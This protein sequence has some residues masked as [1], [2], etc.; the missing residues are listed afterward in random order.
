M[1]QASRQITQFPRSRDALDALTLSQR[2]KVDEESPGPEIHVSR[3]R[4]ARGGAGAKSDAAWGGE[5]VALLLSDARAGKLCSTLALGYL[6]DFEQEHDTVRRGAV[7]RAILD[8]FFFAS[9]GAWSL[10][11]GYSALGM[12]RFSWHAVQAHEDADLLTA[13]QCTGAFILTDVPHLTAKALAL[14]EELSRFF[15]EP[16]HVKHTL[17][18]QQGIVGYEQAGDASASAEQFENRESFSFHGNW[19]DSRAAVA[20]YLQEPDR[21]LPTQ[22]RGVYTEYLRDVAH[23]ACALAAWIESCLRKS[24]TLAD[25]RGD[26]SVSF[27]KTFRYLG[28]SSSS[29]PTSVTGNGPHTDWNLLTLICGSRMADLQLLDRHTQTW[30]ACECAPD[31]AEFLV[32]VGDF[33]EAVSQGKTHSPVHRVNL[34]TQTRLSVVYFLYPEP[35]SIVPGWPY[36]EDHE[37]RKTGLYRD[38]SGRDVQPLNGYESWVAQGG[39]RAGDVFAAKWKQVQRTEEQAHA[40]YR[41]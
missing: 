38:Q 14:L 41:P 5:S 32:L 20:P 29:Q 13:L 28:T 35:N 36:A 15:A 18:S 30:M 4:G 12:Q 34:A 39:H 11:A 7:A 37:K 26:S 6:R 23:V 8:T 24:G 22:N 33:A 25:L 17:R 21:F 31:A 19:A 1:E 16:S 9:L 3:S 40:S 10:Q 27:C 2:V